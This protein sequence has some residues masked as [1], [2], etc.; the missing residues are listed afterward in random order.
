[1]YKYRDFRDSGLVWK[2]LLVQQNIDIYDG[3]EATETVGIRLLF[4]CSL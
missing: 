4:Y 1:M 3:D 2:L